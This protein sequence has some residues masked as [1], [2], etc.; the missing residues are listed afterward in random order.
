MEIHTDKFT[1]RKRLSNSSSKTND[2]YINISKIII[3]YHIIKKNLSI[4][5]SRRGQRKWG[6]GENVENGKGI[7][8]MKDLLSRFLESRVFDLY[9]KKKGI[10]IDILVLPMELTPFGGTEQI[11]C[12]CGLLSSGPKKTRT[13]T[14]TKTKARNEE[15][16]TCNEN[17]IESLDL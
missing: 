8:S 3:S 1:K 12:V 9:K 15:R 4:N 10:Y 14:Q 5:K 16:E 13:R 11:A 17:E 2:N 7:Q 6:N